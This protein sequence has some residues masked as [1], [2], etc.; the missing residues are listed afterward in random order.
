MIVTQSEI[1]RAINDL[2]HSGIEIDPRTWRIYAAQDVDFL[3]GVYPLPIV[4]TNKAPKGTVF[5]AEKI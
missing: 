5:L 3:G 2:E 4:Q 1:Q